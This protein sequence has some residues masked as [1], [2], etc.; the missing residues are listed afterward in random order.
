MDQTTSNRALAP[1]EHFGFLI[2]RTEYKNEAQWM[3]FMAF[4]KYQARHSLANEGILEFYEDIDWKVIVTMPSKHTLRHVL[5]YQ[6]APGEGEYQVCER[7]NQWLDSGEERENPEN[8]RY[9]A[10]VLVCQAFLDFVDQFM[11]GKSL[12]ND[13]AVDKDGATFVLVVSRHKKEGSVLVSI[14]HLIPRAGDMIAMRGEGV[15]WQLLWVPKGKIA[16]AR[17]EIEKILG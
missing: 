13:G 3:R 9:H 16:T 11:K 1:K 7:F 12:E 15:G 5:I 17:T 14:P 4:L 10:C 8:Y 2:Y 6:D